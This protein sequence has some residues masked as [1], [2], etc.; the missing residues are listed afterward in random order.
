MDKTLM[1]YEYSLSEERLKPYQRLA[2][3]PDDVIPLYLWNIALSSALMPIIALLE[4]TLRNHVDGA[5][6]RVAPQWLENEWEGWKP[7]KQ[8]DYDKHIRRVNTEF[9]QFQTLQRKLGTKARRG[10]Y[11]AELTF[12]FWTGLFKSH[13]KTLVWVKAG[14]LKQVFPHMTG[15]RKDPV[16]EIAHRLKRIRLLRNRIFHHEPIFHPHYPLKEIYND[17]IEL[18][19][20]M[21]P[22]I[23]SL[24]KQIDEFGEVFKKGCQV[25]HRHD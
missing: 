3:S 7:Y 13:Y 25:F 18:L 14:A 24:L 22:E 2:T 23:V 1:P 9:E 10:Q 19:T 12:G 17:M 4:V 16:S 5:I 21:N 6:S 11:I 15:K 8:K 20:W